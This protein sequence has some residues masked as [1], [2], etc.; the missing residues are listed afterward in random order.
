TTSGLRTA[1]AG[2][3]GGYVSLSGCLLTTTARGPVGETRPE[4]SRTPTAVAQPFAKKAKGKRKAAEVEVSLASKR[5]KKA[6]A[7]K[8]K[9]KIGE[10]SSRPLPSPPPVVEVEDEDSE[11]PL[12]RSRHQ[13]PK[14]DDDPPTREPVAQPAQED[15]NPD[16]NPLTYD[17]SYLPSEPIPSPLDPAYPESEPAAELDPRP[18]EPLRDH[19][20]PPA[21]NIDRARRVAWTEW[22]SAVFDRQAPTGREGKGR[23]RL[24]YFVVVHPVASHISPHMASDITEE[25][26]RGIYEGVTAPGEGSEIPDLHGATSCRLLQIS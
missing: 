20:R 18:T 7:S 10:S 17:D 11:P 21:I 24:P 2:I 12:R 15:E 13:S 25:F 3:R 1:Q 9:K 19:S 16:E 14:A 6:G 8:P 22:A 5:K 23:F 4:P 26:S